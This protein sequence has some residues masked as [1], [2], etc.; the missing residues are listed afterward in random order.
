MKKLFDDYVYENLEK[1]GNTVIN[2][3]FYK[4]IGK[5]IVL[6]DLKNNG[7]DCEIKIYPHLI[8]DHC[9][10]IIQNDNDIIIQVK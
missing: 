10:L 1:Y 4:K 6:S 5:K 7:F 2:D 9:G 8:K 3:N